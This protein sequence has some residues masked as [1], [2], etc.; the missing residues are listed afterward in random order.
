MSCLRESIFSNSG[1]LYKGHGDVVTGGRGVAPGMRLRRVDIDT[2]PERS[3]G[4]LY[5]FGDSRA[6]AGLLRITPPSA[7]DSIDRDATR[8]REVVRDNSG[9]LIAPDLTYV[10]APA[11]GAGYIIGGVGTADRIERIEDEVATSRAAQQYAERGRG[12]F[13]YRYLRQSG[14]GRE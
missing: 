8:R 1:S 13:R 9:V 7:R 14:L 4:T 12:H 11:I 3:R 2:E 10:Q 5:R 6:L